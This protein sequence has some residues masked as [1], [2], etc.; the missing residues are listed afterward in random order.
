MYV[1]LERRIFLAD[2]STGRDFTFSLRA[3]GAAEGAVFILDKMA[4]KNNVL[5]SFGIFTADP[6]GR[7]KTYIEITKNCTVSGWIS[8]QIELI[9]LFTWLCRLWCNRADTRTSVG[10]RWGSPDE[11]SEREICFSVCVSLVWSFKRL[12]SCLASAWHRLRTCTF[13]GEKTPTVPPSSLMATPI[14]ANSAS[15]QS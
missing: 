14:S 3:S 6:E 8:C 4:T 5:A 13:L 10:P 15:L 11:A 9:E 7:L 1:W 2:L 12:R